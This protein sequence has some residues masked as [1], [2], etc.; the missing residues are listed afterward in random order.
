MPDLMEAQSRAASARKKRKQTGSL[1]SR[2]PDK[3]C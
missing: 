3:G 2:S 1:N